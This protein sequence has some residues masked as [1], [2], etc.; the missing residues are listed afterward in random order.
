[1]LQECKKIQ[2][3]KIAD[4]RG[5]LTFIEGHDV[6][7]AIVGFII[8]MMFPVGKS[9]ACSQRSTSSLYLDVR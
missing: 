2:F 3:P 9:G 5:N 4:S 1:M 6:P 7:F 8:Y